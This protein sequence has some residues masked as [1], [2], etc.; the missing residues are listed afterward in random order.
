[1]EHNLKAA[2]Y[3]LVSNAHRTFSMIDHMRGHKASLNKFKKNEVISSIFSN[4][5]A[6]RLEMNY[7]EKNVK[8]ANTWRINNID[9]K[10]VV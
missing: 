1:M 7:R 8:N 4:H 3:T 10:S 9:R 5:N 2:E 6:M